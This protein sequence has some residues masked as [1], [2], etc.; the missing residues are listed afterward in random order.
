[1]SIKPFVLA[2]ALSLIAATNPVLAE[3]PA[4]ATEALAAAAVL[5]AAAAAVAAPHTL[6][7]LKVEAKASP[8]L[9]PAQRRAANRKAREELRRR[10]GPS[11]YVFN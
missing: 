3:S 8:E 1:M 9:T 5:P 4:A 2:S 7:D 6:E 11:I 10:F